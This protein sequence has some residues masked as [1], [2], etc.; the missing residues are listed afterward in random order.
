M[1]EAPDEELKKATD[2]PE[3]EEG[4]EKGEEVGEQKNEPAI[5]RS[6]KKVAWL[7]VLCVPTVPHV[8]RHQL[9]DHEFSDGEGISVDYV[10]LPF[11]ASCM[12]E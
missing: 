9:D 8:P 10:W 3:Q 11:T 12:L 1:A 7:V 6:G 2:N 5:A 4:G